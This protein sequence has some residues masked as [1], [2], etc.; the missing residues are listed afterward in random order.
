PGTGAAFPGGCLTASCYRRS[1]TGQHDACLLGL[2]SSRTKS[3]QLA[4]KGLT[5]HKP[6]RSTGR[7]LTTDYMLYRLLAGC[8]VRDRHK[9]CLSPS[10]SLLGLALFHSCCIIT[11]IAQRRNDTKIYTGLF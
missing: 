10:P 4:R 2:P 9:T 3:G 6:P 11:W 7:S 5:S 8:R 1:L